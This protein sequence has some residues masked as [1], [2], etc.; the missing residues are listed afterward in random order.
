MTPAVRR[1]LAEFLGTFTLVAIGP[2]AA[3]VA[4][5]THAFGH[6]GVSLAFG[7]RCH[8]H[9][10]GE[11]AS[12]RRA[13]RTQRSPSALVGASL[14]RPRS[15]PLCHRAVHGRIRRVGGARLAPRPGRRLR[16]DDPAALALARLRDRDWLHRHSGLRHNE[17]CDRR[18]HS[19]GRR[20]IRDRRDDLCGGVVTGPFTGGSFNPARSL[21]PA[22][23]GGVWTAH[24][25]YWAAPILGAVGGMRLYELLRTASAPAVPSPR[26]GV[27]GPLA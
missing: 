23:I 21:G 25:L 12:E 7:A 20:P 15:R 26:T 6:L 9:R 3:M 5:R 11:R 24:W 1:Y 13:R 10:G 2:G 14:P 16:R 4:A 17:R 22:V 19:A 18:A 8:H 27:E